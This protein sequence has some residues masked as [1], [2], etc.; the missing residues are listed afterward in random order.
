[1]GPNGLIYSDKEVNSSRPECK[2]LYI[3]PGNI[4]VLG[5]NLSSELLD[6]GL[7]D[8]FLDLTQKSEGKKHKNK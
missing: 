2:N 8:E 3:R 4:K 7:S 6:I 1:M 5:K